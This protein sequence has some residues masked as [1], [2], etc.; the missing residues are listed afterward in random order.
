MRLDTQTITALLHVAAP[1]PSAPGRGDAF[2]AELDAM[3]TG[4]GRDAADPT[5]TDPASGDESGEPSETQTE[6]TQAPQPN[7]PKAQTLE[8]EPDPTGIASEEETAAPDPMTR[9]S[10]VEETDSAPTAA[11]PIS[12]AAPPVR[13]RMT[14][15]DPAGIDRPRT[16]IGRQAIYR[17]PRKQTSDTSE[18]ESK[19]AVS[20]PR[21]ETLAPQLISTSGP[22]HPERAV[23]DDAVGALPMAAMTPE[24]GRGADRPVAVG[25]A[26][27][28]TPAI[29]VAEGS[30]LSATVQ[31]SPISPIRSALAPD[32]PFDLPGQSFQLQAASSAPPEVAAGMGA[33]ADGLRT[34]EMARAVAYDAPQPVPAAPQVKAV[35]EAVVA[36]QGDRVEVA[37]S[38][39]ELGRVRIAMTRSE[40]GVSVLVT[41]ERGETAGLLKRHAEQLATALREAGMGQVDISFEDRGGGGHRAGLPWSSAADFRTDEGD[42]V[43]EPVHRIA[44]SSLDRVDLRL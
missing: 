38:P 8:S 32:A 22:L 41:A 35:A 10:G 36:A 24:K 13:P 2:R 14:R 4:E 40:D 11:V 16:E 12:D 37:L 20:P 6:D 18:R 7:D 33:I 39:E 28:K 3:R 5:P 31:V 34:P 26:A 21:K 43:S 29:D 30:I 44:L 17:E 9:E 1:E 15:E 42:A 19:A 23:L 27:T 25:T